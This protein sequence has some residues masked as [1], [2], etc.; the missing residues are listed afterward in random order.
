MVDTKLQNKAGQA[1]SED[2]IVEFAGNLRGNLIRPGDADYETSRQN[3]NAL[4]DKH[5]GA[6][7]RCSGT[8]D[9]AAAVNFARQ[10]DILVAIR[11]GGHNVG[12]RALCNDGLVID[13]SGM[14]AVHVDPVARTVRVQGGA[15]LGDVDRETYVHG[16]A[17][18]LGVISKT[19]AAGL[20][21]AGGVGWLIRKYGTSCDNVLEMEVVTADGHVRTVNTKENSD[22][23][24]AMR[25]GGGN[26]GVVTSFLYRA[27]PVSTVLGGL[28]VYP[29]AAASE[30][31]RGYR[32]FMAS[33]P[34]ELTVYA[35]MIC[36]PDGVPATAV[37]PCWIGDDMAAGEEAI[38]PL[39]QLGEPMM[40]AVEQMPF[41][42]MQSVLDDAYPDGTRNYWKSAYV[43]GLP[44]AAIDI[45]VEQAKGMTSPMSALL[46]EFH[47]GASTRSASDAN[48]FA[49]RRSD[50]LIGF[51]PQW[52]D[53]S[54]DADHIAWARGAWN[55]IQPYAERGYL[56]SY[57]SEDEQHNVP[58]AF[59]S[60]Y[61]RL[62]Q[63]K[64]TYDPANFFSINQNIQPA[65]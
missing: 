42:A 59:G 62:R 53:A 36:T 25:G 9:V 43:K 8:A 63:L 29:R 21:L 50:Y 48:A 14:R 37:L 10:N 55:A 60:N 1:V 38:A 32:D 56:L 57:L 28:I 2:K 17:V 5:P 13:L 58:E 35:G 47:G 27:H 34:D 6:I 39:K 24:W 11:G 44:D 46:I 52:T 26:F 51:M 16:L 49:Q 65:A 7:L 4:V 22:L 31:L 3:W 12:G 54:E 15:T 33:A 64:K 45:L 30:V 19:G 18:P 61:D 40:V 20:T 23:F 41:P